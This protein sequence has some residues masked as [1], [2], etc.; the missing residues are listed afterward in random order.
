MVDPIAMRV[1]E[2]N[3]IDQAYPIA[4][5][6]NPQIGAD[7]WRTFAHKIIDLGQLMTSTA[8]Q[9]DSDDSVPPCGIM[10]AQDPNG[11]IRGLFVYVVRPSLDHGCV[12]DVENFSVIDLFDRDAIAE[13]MLAQ[14]N[15]IAT[16]HKCEAIHAIL[17]RCEG[18]RTVYRGRVETWF[19]DGGMWSQAEQFCGPVRT[20]DNIVDFDPSS[21]RAVNS[22]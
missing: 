9:C 8:S 7:H 15:N 3:K 16:Q 17:P 6:L 10:T 4:H 21:R 22:H 13:K 14:V 18:P 11:Y 2:R 19:C 5:A 12:L 1:L 20:S